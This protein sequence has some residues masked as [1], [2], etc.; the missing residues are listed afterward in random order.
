MEAVGLL[1]FN[2]PSRLSTFASAKKFGHVNTAP[3]P[4]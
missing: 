3:R 4:A 1:G 2:P